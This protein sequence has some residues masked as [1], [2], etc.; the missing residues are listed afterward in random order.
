[1]TG[2]GTNRYATLLLYLSDVGE[3]EDGGGETVFVQAK[4]YNV[5]AGIATERSEEEVKTE[6][7]QLLRDSN[8]SHLLPENSW[9][10]NLV[11]RCR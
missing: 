8:V 2:A 5:T 3:G 9:Q 1:M 10:R 11:V 7:E 4:P 6:V